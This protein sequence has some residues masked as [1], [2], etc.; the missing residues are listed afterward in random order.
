M[1][2]NSQTFSLKNSKTRFKN[3]L[4]NLVIFAVTAALILIGTV[5]SFAAD[6]NSADI[7]WSDAPEV[8]GTS[9][10]MIDGGSG[11]VLYEKNSLERRDPASITKILT[12]L[13]V[14]E[15]MDLDEK[16]T[17]QHDPV[18]TGEKINL[19]KGEVITVRELLYGMMLPSA[20]DAAETLALAVGGDMNTFC[21]MMNDRAKECGAKNTNFTNANGLNL[22]GQ[23][24]HRTTAYDMAMVA[25]EAM[26]NETFRKLVSTKKH[27]IPPTNMSDERVIENTN[28]CLGL[29][30][31]A[32]GIK[33]GTTSVAGYCFCG[34]AKKDD[35][36]LIVVNLDSK[37]NLRFSETIKLWDY[38]FSKYYTH[39]AAY[40]GKSLD[41]V[42]VKRGD[43][44]SVMVGAEENLAVTL[45]K[46]FDSKNIKIKYD[47]DDEELRAPMKKGTEVGMVTAYNKDNETLA[48]VPLVILE[49]VEKGG[50]LSYIG[51]A[52]EDRLFFVFG[53]VLLFIL[54]IIVMT[55]INRMK[56]RKYERR[57]AQRQRTVR[58]REREREKHPF[59]N[60]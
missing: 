32:T 19:K 39:I 51:I 46:D 18:K 22:P 13:V 30:D 25:K 33:T 34:S 20:N 35:T 8:A 37:E 14:L 54:F 41:D 5:P 49:P 38:G 45:N 15:N 2:L 4:R 29:Y 1:D 17:V 57:R 60:D 31:G 12:C 28:P 11:D 56:R 43:L 44:R 26:K 42:R 7:D 23:G 3:R 40:K 47:L 36:E 10:I 59:N 27:T 58:R 50:I 52:D 53:I 6:K 55:V 48:S 21:K 9:V 16:I 24:K